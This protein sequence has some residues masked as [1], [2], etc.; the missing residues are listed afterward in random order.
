MSLHEK[1]RNKKMPT[2]IYTKSLITPSL[3][4]CFA[5]TCCLFVINARGK[6]QHYGIQFPA[7][8]DLEE[9]DGVMS[10]LVYWCRHLLVPFFF[11]K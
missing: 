5:L 7:C 2:P 1:E 3:H 9:M 11:M 10:D 8:C 6:A 4:L